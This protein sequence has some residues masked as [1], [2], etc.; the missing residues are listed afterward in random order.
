MSRT[1]LIALS[2]LS[3]VAGLA[4]G[5]GSSNNGDEVKLVDLLPASG[6]V[7]GWTE[8]T[9]RGEEGPEVTETVEGATAWV[10]GA[11]DG[12]V[13]SGGWV[14]LAREFYQNGDLLIELYIHEWT[15]A[16]A[17][18]TGYD[19]LAQYHSGDIPNWTDVSLGAGEAACHTAQVVAFYWY[20]DA[21]KDKYLIEMTTA[22]DDVE[23]AEQAAEDFATAVLNK[24]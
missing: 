2:L 24:I 11:M 19:D 1:I 10:D 4:A 17:A 16:A 7:A 18:A 9:A 12:F 23:G 8:N 6:E 14:A 13:E 22:P 15:D 21:H 20:L 3:L 5:C